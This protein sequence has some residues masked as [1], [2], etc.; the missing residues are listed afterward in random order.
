MSWS[1]RSNEVRLTIGFIRCRAIDLGRANSRSPSAPWI[2]PNPESPEPPN[3]SDGIPANEMTPLMA[4]MPLRSARAASMATF[5]FRGEH[6]RRPGRSGWR[7]PAPR[8][9]PGRRPW[10]TVM[11]GPNVS[12]VTA[13]L[14]SGTSAR[15]TGPDVRRAG[16]WRCRRPPAGRRGPG[17]G[18][19]LLD[20]LDLAGHGHRPVVGLPVLARP[21]PCHPLGQLL[22]ERVVDVL[23]HVD[24]LHPDAGLAAV[25]DRAPGAGVGRRV[26]VG[27]RADQERVLA[28]ALGHQ[29]RQVLRAGG[30]D[31]LRGRRRAGERDLVHPA[32]GQRVA[33]RRRTR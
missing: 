3:G 25:G 20:H 28:A 17:V 14:S 22:Q 24:P 13:R 32:A 4:V 12:S 21:Q 29:R 19:V 15:M 16:C 8:P 6:R 11:V 26:Q 23:D 7:W 10:S 31:L 27:V 33:G 30:H 9:R 1:P 18:D 2:R 5:L